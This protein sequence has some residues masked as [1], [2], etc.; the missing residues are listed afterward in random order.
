M[1]AFPVEP[2]VTF[3]VQLDEIGPES[4]IAH[5]SEESIVPWR[6]ESNMLRK[7]IAGVLRFRAMHERSVPQAVV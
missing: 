7:R 1:I 6:H 5:G 2:E 3:G 4:C